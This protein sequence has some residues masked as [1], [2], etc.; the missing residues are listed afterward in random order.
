MQVVPGRCSGC[1]HAADELTSGHRRA[2]GD[3]DVVLMSVV[4]DVPICVSDLREIAVTATDPSEN[5]GAGSNRMDPR[6][7]GCTEIQPLMIG[8]ADSA[9]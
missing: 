8:T 9:W 6:I 3:I 7:L 4:A 2:V 1:A 5:D